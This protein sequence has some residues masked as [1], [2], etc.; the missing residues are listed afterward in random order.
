M[1][2][3]EADKGF[4]AEKGKVYYLINGNLTY[5]DWWHE[6]LGNDPFDHSGILST[7]FIRPGLVYGLSDK[8]NIY[9]NST[10]GIRQMYWGGKKESGFVSLQWILFKEMSGSKP[11]YGLLQL[12]CSQPV[13]KLHL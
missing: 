13:K 4:S 8:L 5:I 1:P 10:L 2:V 6:A 3:G 12:L 11:G 7:Y 9:I